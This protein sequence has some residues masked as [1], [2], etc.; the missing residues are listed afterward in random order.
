MNVQLLNE[1]EIKIK[2]DQDCLFPVIFF[3][4]DGGKGTVGGKLWILESF[5]SWTAI[6]CW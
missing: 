2:T 6:F 4:E 5:Q 3:L 1:N